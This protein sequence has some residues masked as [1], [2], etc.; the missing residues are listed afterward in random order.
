M[1]MIKDL[2]A[3]GCNRLNKLLL[4]I[5]DCEDKQE[6]IRLSNILMDE[7]QAFI[8]LIY[9]EN[10]IN[11]ED[12]AKFKQ[13]LI[14]IEKEAMKEFNIEENAAEGAST[15]VGEEQKKPVDSELQD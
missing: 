12:V 11:D 6:I 9:V 10:E 1:D 15:S 2:S 8:A 7:I 4:K 5:I 13:G 14:D 3:K